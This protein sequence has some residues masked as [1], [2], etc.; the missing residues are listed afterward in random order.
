MSNKFGSVWNKWDFHVHTPYSIL[1]NG[2]GFNPF[3]TTEEEHE[4]YFDEYVKQLFTKAIENKIVAIGITDYFMIN[5][6][7]RIVTKYLQNPDKM[8]ELFPEDDI[9]SQIEKIFV[10]PNIELRLNTFVGRNSHS[11]NYHVIFSNTIPIYEIENNFLHLL[12]FQSADNRKLQLTKENIKI[13]GREVKRLNSIDGNDFLVGLQNIALDYNEIIHRLESNPVFSERYIITIPVD[14]DLS[15][16]EWKG[17]DYTT[18]KDLYRQCS[19]YMTANERTAIWALAEGEE[20]ER[21][22]EFGALK[23]CI[24]GSDAHS[25]ETM[26]LPKKDRFCW[27]KAEPSFE[28][29]RQ[30][31]YEPKERV[32]I[33]KDCP[34]D[35]DIHQ[36]IESIQ[37]T[38]GNFQKEPIVFNDY[39]TCIIGGKSTGKSLLLQQLAKAIDKKYANEQEAIAL[40]NRKPLTI[41]KAVVT[42][43]DGTNDTRKIV[44]IPQTFLNRTIDNPEK[45]TAINNIIADVLKQE[46]A[47]SKAFSDL[48]ENLRVIRKRTESNV[49]EY[50]EKLQT[51]TKLIDAIKEYGS[52]E[53]FEKTLEALET[54]RSVLAKEKDI[55]DEDIVR[56]AELEK[57]IKELEGKQ[58]IYEQELENYKHISNPVV[59]I[60]GYFFS[61]DNMNVQHSFEQKFP[62][63]N[64]QLQTAVNEMSE[65][66]I[67]KWQKINNDLVA[68]LNKL[69]DNNKEEIERLKFEYIS[70]KPQIEQNEKIQKLSLQISTEQE[71]LK[72][73]KEN[74]HKKEETERQLIDLQNNI[75]KSQEEF[76]NA[77][78]DYCKVVEDTGTEKDTDLTFKAQPVWK[79]EDFQNALSDIFDNRKYSSFNSEYKYN[80][81]AF[82]PTDY[83]SDLLNKIWKAMIDDSTNGS[84]TIK[85]GYTLYNALQQIFKDWYN[86]HY[87]V[88]SG[89]DAIDEMSPGKKALVLLELLINL[90]DSKCPILIDQ[91]EDD[92]DNRSIYDDLVQYIKKKKKERQIIVVTHNANVVLG[93]D[94]EEV[95]IANQDGK[96]TKNNTKRFEYRSG[97]IENDEK[98]TDENGN[99][100][101]GILN[102]S[103]IQTQICD[104]LEGGKLAFELRK[105]KYNSLNGFSE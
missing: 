38:D 8:K 24:W 60:P 90:E 88:K 44:Y 34:N 32:I 33:Q 39:L 31:L 48:E 93:A 91:P 4:K 83:N 87:I 66:L 57:Q 58:S 76:L 49:S 80:L 78:N 68:H 40:L 42:W 25:Y 47:I 54:E 23:P 46:P 14:E 51:L 15:N 82:N 77:Y 85:S 5:G 81:A 16:I 79:Q 2:Y 89:N 86:I 1:N 30:I 59:I 29:L 13:H 18:R 43:K 99:V 27:I 72:K 21:I 11:I 64:E 63:T 3:E 69:S 36:I 61:I 20:Q 100:I 6:Y 98:L 105:N 62:H 53:S 41:D 65:M 103:G 19:C 12:E 94:A 75:L 67:P 35:K 26:F 95:I 104:I 71:K 73:A 101:P 22:D 28:G 56:Y 92:L 97:A 52:P 96:N 74:Q 17:R 55:K 50:C 37:F 70:L 84:L 7:K 9:R 102:Q 45:E 10:F